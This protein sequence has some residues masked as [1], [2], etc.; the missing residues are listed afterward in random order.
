MHYAFLCLYNNNRYYYTYLFM[1]DD[2]G[3]YVYKVNVRREDEIVARLFPHLSL[4]LIWCGRLR[5]RHGVCKR[6]RATLGSNLM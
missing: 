3:F 5:V 1:H 6:A 2:F 4:L